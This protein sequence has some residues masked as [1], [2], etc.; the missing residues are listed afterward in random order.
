M[1]RSLRKQLALRMRLPDLR[2]VQRHPK[3]TSPRSDEDIA[4]LNSQ[5]AVDAEGH[6]VEVVPHV[7]APGDPPRGPPPPEPINHPHRS[8]TSSGDSSSSTDVP[9]GPPPAPESPHG[10]WRS[11]QDEED[12]ALVQ[13]YAV[14]KT[15]ASTTT[16]SM[17]MEPNSPEDTVRDAVNAQLV[18]G[19]V[20]DTVDVIRRLLDR[21]RQLRHRDRLL[22]VA[23][24]EILAWLRVP[25]SAMPFNA[26]GMAQAICEEIRRQARHGSGRVGDDFQNPRLDPAVLL[27]PDLPRT[28]DDVGRAFEHSERP[29]TVA[30]FRR[31]AWR[32]HVADLHRREG[33]ELP[34]PLHPA[35]DDR[36]LLLLQ[37][38]EDEMV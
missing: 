36:R 22:G 28:L 10:L 8:S 30:G 34:E 11:P 12:S 23:L 35:P 7:P 20:V 24:E 15:S 4:S 37:A 38:R 3:K 16:T 19:N 2:I 6:V 1:W 33:A 26:R 18:Q 5:F 31:R 13:F 32:Q 14:M 27:Q 21:Q 17:R 9:R 29:S 25:L